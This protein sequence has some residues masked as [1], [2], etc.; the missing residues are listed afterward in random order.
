MLVNVSG[1][2]CISC[3]KFTQYYTLNYRGE[4]ERT[5][6][7]YCGQRGMKVRPGDRCRKYVEMSNCAQR[8]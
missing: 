1:N 6:C 7:G 5:D 4:M 3:N 2:K 8:R